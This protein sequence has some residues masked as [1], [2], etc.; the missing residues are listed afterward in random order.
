MEAQRKSKWVRPTAPPS[1]GHFVTDSST[2]RSGKEAM[3]GKLRPVGNQYF[4]VRTEVRTWYV[5]ALS[6]YSSVSSTTVALPLLAG[7]IVILPSLL[8]ELIALFSS[9]SYQ[10]MKVERLLCL[11][12]RNTRKMQ[13]SNSLTPR[14]IMSLLSTQHRSRPE[15]SKRHWTDL[16]EKRV[17]V[18]L[19]CVPYHQRKRPS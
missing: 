6:L 18:K 10:L 7:R 1:S 3:Q 13:P 17:Y 12:Q 16:Y 9:H 8:S 15:Q 19:R 4:G 11:T 5:V 2:P 14:R